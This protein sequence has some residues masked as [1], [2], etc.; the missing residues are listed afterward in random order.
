[1]TGVCLAN[2]LS[3][4]TGTENYQ[5]WLRGDDVDIVK[6][7]KLYTIQCLS[8]FLLERRTTSFTNIFGSGTLSV[9]YRILRDERE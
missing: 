2:L 9:W 5:V 8:N 7:S 6:V 4:C 3:V 1:M